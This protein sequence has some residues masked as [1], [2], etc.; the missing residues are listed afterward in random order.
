MENTS[1]EVIAFALCKKKLESFFGP[2]TLI[3]DQVDKP[4]FAIELVNKERIGVEITAIDNQQL[5]MD[6]NTNF[7]INLEDWYLFFKQNSSNS[8]LGLKSKDIELLKRIKIV[9]VSKSD[10]F[11]ELHKEYSV[12]TT[13]NKKLYNIFIKSLSKAK[14]DKIL[15]I[16][17]R[18]NNTYFLDKTIINNQFCQNAIHPK[19]KRFNEVYSKK[20][21]KTLLILH[22][23]SFESKNLYLDLAQK[24]SDYLKV[25][26][27]PFDKIL[28]VDF[29]HKEFIGV[30]YDKDNKYKKYFF[31]TLVRGKDIYEEHASQ[32]FNVSSADTYVFKKYKK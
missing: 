23:Q 3:R 17:N 22:C 29:K 6:K 8:I 12:K 28:L 18:E 14:R 1:E 25:Q 10:G 2:I 11:I 4:D 19:I 7:D 21:P 30:V 24:L 15:A 13:S 27:N 31:A 16:K 5:I 9:D 32:Y 26:K 20:Y